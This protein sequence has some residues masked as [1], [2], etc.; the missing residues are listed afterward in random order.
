MA[1]PV[2]SGSAPVIR[3]QD[4]V[5]ANGR[6]NFGDEISHKIQGSFR[7]VFLNV[8][9]FAVNEAECS[10]TSDMFCFMRKHDVDFFHLW[11][12]DQTQLAFCHPETGNPM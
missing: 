3:A 11:S 12:T 10:K 2:N 5:E 9:N 1:N 7:H 4:A 6:R 8:G